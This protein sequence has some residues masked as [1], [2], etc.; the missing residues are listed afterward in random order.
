MIRQR[1]DGFLVIMLDFGP[2]IMIVPR[3]TDAR[4]IVDTDHAVMQFTTDI[5]LKEFATIGSYKL[6]LAGLTVSTST[7]N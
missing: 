3:D 1:F 4:R 2:S 7:L 6:I 5:M